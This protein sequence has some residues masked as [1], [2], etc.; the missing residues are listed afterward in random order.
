MVCPS[1][2]EMSRPMIG[3][4]TWRLEGGE[5]CTSRQAIP[6]V[7]VGGLRVTSCSVSS[8]PTG[9]A[10]FQL[11]WRKSALSSRA[12]GSGLAFQH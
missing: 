6:A 10:S 9:L 4:P 8:L 5:L 7:I 2:R 11:R 3:Q 1:L 12:R